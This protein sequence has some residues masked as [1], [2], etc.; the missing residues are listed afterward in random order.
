MSQKEAFT[1]AF[2]DAFAEL[3]NQGISKNEA[4]A[5]AIL[6]AKDRFDMKNKS[7]KIDTTKVES[8]ITATNTTPIPVTT[9]K[10]QPIDDTIINCQYFLDVLNKCKDT[11]N[12]SAIIRLGYRCFSSSD[13]LNNMFGRNNKQHNNDEIYVNISEVENI[14]NAILSSKNESIFSCV[15]CGL[16]SLT[17]S[18]QSTVSITYN[19]TNINLLTQFIVMLDHPDLLDPRMHTLLKN[20]IGSIDKLPEICQQ[21]ISE[22]I[23]KYA[24]KSSIQ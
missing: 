22:W 21:R 5:K 12:Y 3:T 10:I 18:L 6:L 4:T 15:M 8:R 23:G 13:I 2:Q 11:D 16:E 17:F 1:K 14:Y 9:I 7:Q 24:G 19:E 20:L